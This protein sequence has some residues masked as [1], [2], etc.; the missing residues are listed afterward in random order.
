MLTIFLLYKRKGNKYDNLP[1]GP[2]ALPLIGSIP[3]LKGKGGPVGWMVDKSLYKYG[4]DF[5]T[6]WMGTIPF[7]WIQDYKLAKELFAKDEFSDRLNL[8]YFKNVRG[9]HGRTLG[10]SW[11]SG[12]F[13]SE[14][15]RFA[16]KHLKDLGFGK[17]SLVNVVQEEATDCIN[18]IISEV[19]GNGK[20]DILFQEGFFNFPIINILW[21]IIASKKYNS[22]SVE[23]QKI[24]HMLTKFFKQGFPLLDFV[25]AIRPYVPYS[26]IDRNVFA[27][28]ET[29][30]KQ[31]EDHKRTMNAEEEPRDFMDIY[32]REIEIEKGKLGSAYSMET[33][34]FHVEQLVVMCL[35]FFSAGTETTGT[36]MSW[37]MMYLS[38]NERVQRK[39][40]I[41]I[42]ECLGGNDKFDTQ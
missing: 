34:S 22:S 20:K 12:R 9:S 32:L 7:I 13:W 38:L 1:P 3:F 25:P 37:A 15:K 31:I 10:I 17:Q 39:C 19:G 26:E 8:W 24:M 30:R 4:K 29:I 36:T 35:D 27:I 2:F 21:Q 14:Q 28:K 23:T 40:Q 42:D 5:C 41:E 6:I 16:L 33:S 18:T 11:E